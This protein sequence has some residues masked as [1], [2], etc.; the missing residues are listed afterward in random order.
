M[1]EHKDTLEPVCLEK[2]GKTVPEIFESWSDKETTVERIDEEITS[3]F[4]GYRDRADYYDKASCN[5]R[6]PTIATPTVFFNAMDDPIISADCIDYDVF[7]NNKN[8]AVAT[9]EHGGHLGYMESLN[10]QKLWI[11]DPCIKFFNALN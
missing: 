9:T 1:L 7:R 11:I 3:K 5:Y 10:S 8:V 4:F 6:I 2:F